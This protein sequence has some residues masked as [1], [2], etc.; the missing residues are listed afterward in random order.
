MFTCRRNDDKSVAEQLRMRSRRTSDSS[1]FGYITRTDTGD[2]PLDNA[3]PQETTHFSEHPLVNGNK[4]V[5]DPLMYNSN[6]LFQAKIPEKPNDVVNNN[7]ISNGWYDK[8]NPP[9]S[10][11]WSSSQGAPPS[12][13]ATLF[14]SNGLAG[15]GNGYVSTAKDM[16]EKH[17]NKKQKK[18]KPKGRG[19]SFA[20][21]A[22]KI[23]YESE[24]INALPGADEED[25]KS[26][27]RED[28]DCLELDP[29]P[30]PEVT[31]GGNNTDHVDETDNVYEMIP[32]DTK[33]T[34]IGEIN[35]P[36]FSATN[37]SSVINVSQ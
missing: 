32:A 35:N 14:T 28:R 37:G 4:A 16:S 7:S 8:A 10:L 18:E 2:N 29:Y 1:L 23:Y 36:L 24:E 19:V 20:D 5:L 31:P 25:G 3:A 6:T 9:Y 26:L 27:R 30:R 34:L 21:M 13:T 17:K 11:M 33:D 12:T 22:E 15:T